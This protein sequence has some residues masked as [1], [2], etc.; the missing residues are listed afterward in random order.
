M[1]STLFRLYKKIPQRIFTFVFLII[2]VIFLVLYLR[3]ADLSHLRHL[4][5]TWWLVLASGVSGLMFR[6]WMVVI[7]RVIL[8]ALGSRTLPSFNVMAYVYAKAWITRYVPGTVTWIVGKVYM[9]S[10]FGIS[11]SRLAVSS[12][13]EGGMQVVSTTVVS[14]L[15]LGFSPHLKSV[16]YIARLLVV[17][18]SL[19]CLI[20][21]YP[22]I[23]NRLLHVAHVAVKKQKPS[24]ELQ[25]NGNAVI[26]SFVLFAIGTFITGMS[27]FFVVM[28]IVPH[29][30][31][32]WFLY[33]VG[34]FGISGAIGIVTPFLPSGIGVRDGVLLL[35]LAP[36]MPKELAL[37]TTVFTRLWQVAMDSIF[38]GVASLMRA[39]TNPLSPESKRTADE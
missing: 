38:L 35:L 20:T 19:A 18:I 24:E 33:I 2:V 1:V 34:A 28:A 10:S 14:L 25:I 16:P 22:P 17:L 13:L 21:L 3:G 12:V 7:W 5:V 37:A 4:H 27:N 29:A 6:Y 26:R 11:K 30:S 32:D 39:R 8:R 23:F 9:A 15:I 36:I 31:S